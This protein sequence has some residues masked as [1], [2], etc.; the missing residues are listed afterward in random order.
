M[1]DPAT[2]EFARQAADSAMPFAQLLSQR[3]LSIAV[4]LRDGRD[5]EA[6]DSLEA[7]VDDIQAFL[8][9]LVLVR[10]LVACAD[11]TA[12]VG[13][14]D[15]QERVVDVLEALQPALGAADWVEVADSLEADLAPSLEG[16]QSL[17]DRVRT[18]LA[19]AA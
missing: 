5:A 4:A 7:S 17:D 2:F 14:R 1:S 15:Y 3:C 13:L 11:P 6:L 10:D 19:P 18:A 9:Y 12:A 8:A 16:Y